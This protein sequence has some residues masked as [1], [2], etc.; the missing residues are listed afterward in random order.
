MPGQPTWQ[1]TPRGR[2]AVSELGRALASSERG[3]PSRLVL[4]VGAGVDQSI[5]NLPGW[6]ELLR[7]LG[8]GLTFGDRRLDELGD[9]AREWPVETAQALR[10]T[11][12]P[13]DFMARLQRALQPAIPNPPNAAPL[14][15][16]IVKLVTCGIRL[17]V[18]LN[19]S[20]ELA[21][22]LRAGLQPNTTVQ[23]IDRQDLS[24][25]PLGRL[26]EP[27]ADSVHVLKLH[28]SL[29]P[30]QLAEE[31]SMVLDRS[32][33]DAALAANSPYQDILTRVF[34]DFTVL[35][36]G[37]SWS[38]VPL[39]DAAAR[40][41]QRLPVARTMHYATR[42]QHSIRERAWWE[43]RALTSSY[44]LRP[45][46]Y[47]RHHEV[48]EI[49]D[50]IVNIAKKESGP[51]PDAPLEDLAEWL[52]EV[53][54]YESQQQSAW[55]AANW[56]SAAK[57]IQQT[58]GLGTL[59][60][61]Q[62]LA[63]CRVERHLRH[64]IWFW[65]APEKRAEFRKNI[66]QQVATAWERLPP[67]DSNSLW[68]EERIASAI[69]WDT[70]PTPDVR[71]RAL[72]DFAMGTYEIYGPGLAGN[73]VAARWATRLETIQRH[74]PRSVAARRIALAAQVWTTAKASDSMVAAAQDACWEG[75]EAKIAL[76]IGQTRLLAMAAHSAYE[77]PRDWP[78]GQRDSLWRQCDHVR[79]LSRVAG[80]NRREAGAVV[81]AS[82]LAPADQAESNLIAAHRRLRDLSGKSVEPTAQ[83]S[84]ITGLIAVFADQARKV[85]D[86]DLLQPL[87]DW[88]AD[89][90][91]E[92]NVDQ[93]LA[94]V[95]S[96]NFA[97][98]WFR[99]H[100][101][102]GNLAP[103]LAQHLTR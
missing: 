63:A 70:A 2:R 21:R 59:T 18:S 90:C 24:A 49:L 46:Y 82:F 30:I 86:D 42:P 52:D 65:L 87:S 19:Y 55:F 34:E 44:G 40:A 56:E 78:A 28:G 89:K 76:D 36:V 41:R 3:Q 88:I 45:L 61:Q 96:R 11:L 51:S 72:L 25:W 64:F 73:E 7:G 62:W 17:I 50:S 15:K 57:S 39:R 1:A 38:D 80:C 58:C 13:D 22:I 20:D 48:P 91:G 99:F 75:L 69:D 31:T 100:K 83:W 47:D 95:V 29:P 85:T 103:R 16:A 67:T 9:V 4:L 92:I 79:E 77:T 5:G 98:H 43:E 102:A 84:I 32:S 54:D 93:Q 14:A 94:D 60:S 33:Y 81:L 101:R 8:D 68:Q 74:S 97:K 12:G 23:V 35:S 26:L 27:P 37:V 6:T 66:W 53:G 10:L 71:D